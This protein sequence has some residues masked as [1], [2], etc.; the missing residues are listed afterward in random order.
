M[1]L[2][3]LTWDGKTVGVSPTV[4]QA[5]ADF[6]LNASVKTKTTDQNGV[7]NVEHDGNNPAKF[8]L[9]IKLDARL[10]VNVADEVADWVSRSRNAHRS[11]LLITGRDIFSTYFML[12]DVS[13]SNTR[14]MP[15]GTWMCTDL[16]LTFQECYYAS[17]QTSSSGGVGGAGSDSPGGYTSS[18]QQTS[19]TTKT[20]SS[21]PSL[22]GVAAASVADSG[23]GG[24]SSSG[25][26][27]GLVKNVSTSAKAT[28][29]VVS[30][31]KN[32]VS[33]V[34]TGVIGLFKKK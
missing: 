19:S 15:N 9:T 29:S 2:T 22:D 33:K 34:A 24:T 21:S 16:S 14:M 25:N 30:T 27:T 17:A 3:F 32:V 23:T 26:L 11:K 20:K 13:T 10:G 18:G 7:H 5:V 4:I 12:T 8:T 31:V 6:A 28:S 1:A